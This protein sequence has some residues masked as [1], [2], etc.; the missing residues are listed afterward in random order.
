MGMLFS[1]FRDLA[2]PSALQL[3]L[4]IGILGGYTTFS[5][6]GLETMLMIENRAFLHAFWYI[7][8]SNILGI[9]AVIGGYRMMELIR[10]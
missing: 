3:F 9:V 1:F 10:V 7:A 2:T 8:G 6:F 5:S 4:L